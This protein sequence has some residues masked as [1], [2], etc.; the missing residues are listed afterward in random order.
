MYWC[1]SKC[2]LI[3]LVLLPVSILN[4]QQRYESNAI[5]SRIRALFSVA[6]L[7]S[8]PYILVVSGVPPR[9][10]EVLYNYGQAVREVT[11]R[12][13]GNN[14]VETTYKNNTVISEA[15]YDRSRRLVLEKWY[16]NDGQLLEILRHEYAVGY[17][18]V[19]VTDK[20]GQERYT[21]LHTYDLENKINSIIRSYPD[22]KREAVFF[23]FIAEL[24]LR[25]EHIS[26]DGRYLVRYDRWG[27]TAE[28]FLIQGRELRTAEFLSYRQGDEGRT[29]TPLSSRLAHYDSGIVEHR[30][31]DSAGREIAVEKIQDNATIER[32]R[33]EY[34]NRQ[35]SRSVVYTTGSSTSREKIFDGSQDIIEERWID[36]GKLVRKIVPTSAT[37]YYE[38]RYNDGVLFVKIYYENNNR[39]REEFISNDTIVRVREY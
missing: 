13:E 22:Q 2:L 6:P 11:R 14:N 24:L 15:Y 5:G 3:G 36:S 16:A 20:D 19:H 32:G 17:K 27:R 23:D 1:V 38:E 8:Y 18:R 29:R 9:E 28:R 37:T 31:Y 34:K 7:S 12:V 4:A 33:F 35:L 39:I 30:T 25:E 21:E 10:R 26:S